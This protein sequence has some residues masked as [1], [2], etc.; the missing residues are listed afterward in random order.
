MRRRPATAPH[1][2]RMES[3][4]SL[5]AQIAGFQ[6]VPPPGI[7]RVYTLASGDSSE[8]V[9][10]EV[11]V[12]LFPDCSCAYFI[13]MIGAKTRKYVP[14][15]HLYFI[16]LKRMNMAPDVEECIHQQTLSE[17]EVKWL[18]SLDSERPV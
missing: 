2:D 12:S 10:Y 1:L 4:R 6:D 8:G 17:S 18:L 15:K 3:V 9:L 14:C 7:G 16:F 11:M 13:S 5:I